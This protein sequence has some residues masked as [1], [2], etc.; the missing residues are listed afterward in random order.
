MKT[1]TAFASFPLW[2]L[3]AG[4]L[5]A[6]VWIEGESFSTATEL[7]AGEGR[8]QVK[9]GGRGFA[10][11]GWGNT[12][13]MSE[14]R[15]LHV[16]LQEGE[17]DRFLPEEGLV[18]SYDFAV[19]QEAEHDLWARIG[20]EWA[21]SDFQWRL[22]G[23]DWQTCAAT[24]A[25]TDLQPIQTWNELAWIRLGRVSL[26][27]GSH[28]LYV[29]HDKRPQPGKEKTARIL[30]ML[31]CLYLTTEPFLPQGKWRPG[32]E[33]RTERE[34][35]AERQRF[36][37]RDEAG[38]DGRAWTVLD[39]PWQYAAWND[40]ARP[41][42]EGQRLGPDR[43]LPGLQGLRW[44]AY[45]APGGR[46]EQLPEQALCHRYL[47]RT[48]VEVPAGLTG[49]SFFLDVQNS[50]LIVS[51]FVNGQ[52][53]GWTDTFHTAW[54]MDL[55]KALRPGQMYELVLCI[56][57]AYYSLNP[58]EDPSQVIQ[59]YGN[60]GYWSIPREFLSNNQGTA[61]RHDMPVASDL[62][63]GLL[64]P[65]SIV[66]AGP[67]YVDDAFVKPGVAAKQLAAEL[68]LKNPGAAP[69]DVTVRNRVI[70]WNNGTGGVAECTFAEQTIRLEPGT[71]Q[72]LSFV[73]PWGNPRLWWPDNPWLYWLET[74]LV[75]DGKVVDTLRTRFGFR[76]MDWS[77]HQF[78][79]NG[80]NWPMWAD[81]TQHGTPQAFV[82]R[83]R[84][85]SHMNHMRYWAPGMASAG[86]TRRE[87]LDYFD[88]TGMLVRSSGTFDGQ[89]ANYGTGLT[90]TTGGQRGPKQRLWDNWRRQ[91]TAW[92]KE[93]RNHPSVYIWSVENEITY[94]NVAN[95]GQWQEC[96]PEIRKGVEHVMALDP[97]RPA[98][99]DGGNALRDESLPVNGAHYTELMNCAFRD[100]PDAA[101]TREPFY[102]KERPQ[103][104]NWRMVPGR[105][106]MKGEV[107]FANG[108]ST[109][110][111][112]TIGGDQCFIGMSQT[113]AARGLLAKMLSEGYRWAEVASFHFWLDNSDYSHWNSWSPVAVF[114]RQWNWTWGEKSAI[115]RR[116][117]VFNST[118]NP[119]PI[120]VTWSF[121]VGG[122]A[123]A[124]ATR[125]FHIPGGEAEEFEVYFTTPAVK[126]SAEGAFTLQAERNGEV[127]FRDTKPVRLL[128]PM[129][130]DKPGIKA[131]RLAVCDPLGVVKAHLRGRGIGFTEMANVA[132][133]PGEAE[134]VVIGPDAVPADYATHPALLA[135]AAAG[136]KVIVLDQQFPLSYGALPGD[137]QP[138][139][140]TGRFGFMEDATHP[141]FAGL[142][143]GDFFTWGNDH[144]LYRNVYRKA[145][146]G[147]RSLFH[148]DE[149]LG[150]SALIECQPNDGL[151]LISQ[152]A[153]K[154]KLADEAVAQWYFNNLLAYAA[155]YQP[156]RKTTFACVSD[157]QRRTLEAGSLDFRSV[158]TP[159]DTLRG[160]IA[161]VEASPANLAALAAQA[162]QVRAFAENGGWL[163]LWG[164]TPDG[165]KDFNRLVG[166]NH[167]LRP[168]RRERVLLSY[169][170]D[171]LASGLTLKDVVMDTGQKLYPWMA[172]KEPDQNAFL[173]LV[174]H[175]DIAP[176]CAFP[177]PVEM[178]KPSNQPGPDHYPENM[179]N[180]FTSD[181]N[182]VFTYTTMLDEGN[183]TSFVLTLPKEEELVALKIRPSKIYHPLTQ[184]KIYFDDDPVPVVADIPVRLNP[185]TEDI[186]ID[187]RK[188]SRI[189]IEIA[190]WEERGD[191]NI[192]VMDNL[193]LQV[194]RS[195]AYRESVSPLLNVGAL[196]AYRIGEGGLF[197]NQ[198]NL[199]P[200]E[201]NPD[202]TA[203]KQG[204]VKTLLNNLG[205]VIKG[206]QT[207]VAAQPL[208]CQPVEIPDSL[209]NAYT[210]HDGEPSW[211][212][213]GHVRALPA[214]RR[215][216]GGI[217]FHISDFST[218]PVPSV[219]M[220]SGEGS[221]ARTDRIRDIPVN[222]MADTLFFLH[223]ACAGSEA[224]RWEQDSARAHREN[225]AIPA[226][227]AMLTYLVRYADGSEERVPVLYREH[228]SHW[229]TEQP[230]PLPGAALAWVGP[231]DKGAQAAVW[232]MA[233]NNPHPDREIRSIDLI[234]HPRSGAAAVFAI[235]TARK[236]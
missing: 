69:V 72:T 29:R 206:S 147:G 71:N 200:Q 201:I 236:P 27:A 66:V 140:F 226:P 172:L 171:P 111:F 161:V 37:L 163:M 210:H 81:L 97:T 41:T 125:S 230:R 126:P 104:G 48:R 86:A 24:E 33:H 61:G 87:A 16:Q 91:M 235:S 205:A 134:V 50:S 232:T 65:A 225:R 181:D 197:L 68:T 10:A 152:F 46:D 198:V 49:K 42:D 148:C 183:K 223:T 182:W 102:D 63:T 142:R 109:E 224:R 58:K 108:Y 199:L 193:W 53:V 180:G 78:R 143:Q 52:F 116:L 28:T 221:E 153:L 202:N 187:G 31:D 38:S 176:F 141:V 70:P 149:G 44:L 138:T 233:W 234:A 133:A 137:F 96:E 204:I 85:Q 175:D 164:L 119:D 55:S 191:R 195:A 56:K 20:Y 132:A 228:V 203:K 217:A 26:Y 189:T 156:V 75:R 174:D 59:Q 115:T 216:F 14:G 215:T 160:G 177:T 211:F 94:I 188:A 107:Y 145:P 74:E 22:D 13:V 127:V 17:V 162:G 60:R 186:P 229:L 184:I 92:V 23:G 207:E 57:D 117:K 25:T 110:D 32:A 220:L 77:T 3:L 40:T 135:L 64:A 106:I 89:L 218:S 136:K 159:L 4:S 214:G 73:Q 8:A 168:F 139:A 190:K 47:L 154:D 165:L 84:T 51:V 158:A 12:R 9:G 212:E 227:P 130:Q 113:L 21:R 105:P 90:E 39:G 2:L 196:M 95:L 99:I 79:I 151:L 30:H 82:E 54:Q 76:E 222:R 173:W 121:T 179:V 35:T 185:V 114:C 112:A 15:V 93:E 11:E 231:Q 19:D 83:A 18:F 150:Y 170:L 178:G 6:N 194:K 124:G 213:G 1:R 209:F 98:M 43:Q 157:L 219:F 128:A 123:L 45:T 34:L 166:F 101:Y 131:A 36:T 5:P 67:V 169:P 80:V 118:S 146:K 100:F 120:Q 103:R 208:V 167:V 7:R 122:K 144:V 62:R 192:V 129:Q 155:A 88:E